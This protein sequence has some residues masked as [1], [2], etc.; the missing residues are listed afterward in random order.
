MLRL[1][2][3][4]QQ[5]SVTV[6]S[7]TLA[8][9]TVTGYN[10][11]QSRSPRSKPLD[12][13]VVVPTYNE[14]ENLPKLAEIIFG[15]EIPGLHV[16]VV[17]D[18][19]PDG[20]GQVAEELAQ[21]YPGRLSVLH[22]P[23]KMGLGTAYVAGF[24]RVLE[25][26]ADVIVQMDADLSHSPCYLPLMVLQTQ[27]H[28]VVVGSR[29]VETGSVDEQWGLWR[30]F[31]SW[32]ANRVYIPLILG[33]QVKD[34]TAGLKCFRRRVLEAIDLDGLSSSGYIF[35]VEMAY[36]CEK[37]GFDV[38]EVPIFFPDREEGKSKMTMP[39]KLE[40]AWRVWEIGWRYRNLQ[41]LRRPDPSQAAGG[42]R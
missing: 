11:E 7:L 33:L 15:L 16:L 20:T 24:K 36:I 41:P 30:H 1:A 4:L 34:A 29:Y 12:V 28:D 10:R 2:P 23:R 42:R 21:E 14:A 31:L 27:Q 32:F 3:F 26:G 18:S 40:A 9:G 6:C 35:Q 19:S 8:G 17:D 22:R 37:L 38:F 5:N 25:A 13:H 39:V